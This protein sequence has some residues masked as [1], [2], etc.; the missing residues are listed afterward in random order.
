MKT[1]KTRHV[2]TKTSCCH[3]A[4][5]TPL[6]GHGS[7]FFNVRII[8]GYWIIN[9]IVGA[10]IIHQE[11]CTVEILNCMYVKYVGIIRNLI[12]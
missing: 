9:T 5:R 10:V 2:D 7:F 6:N 11:N 4:I 12:Q 3:H 1:V 8:S